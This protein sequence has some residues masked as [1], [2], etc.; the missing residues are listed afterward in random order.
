MYNITDDTIDPHSETEELM[1]N[2]TTKATIA[3]GYDMN[4]GILRV[5]F[6]DGSEAEYNIA[7]YED[8]LNTTMVTRSQLTWLLDNDVF[9][10][11]QLMITGTMQQYLDD[12]AREHR[13][14]YEGVRDQLMQNNDRA[15]AEYLAREFM[16]YDS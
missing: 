8:T 2:V 1:N 7:E 9:S 11:V 6:C 13:S 10:Y 4:D 15:T 5:L 3:A 12:Y 16:M 14:M